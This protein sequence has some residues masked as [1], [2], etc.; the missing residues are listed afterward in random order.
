LSVGK[1]GFSANIYW[2]GNAYFPTTEYTSTMYLDRPLTSDGQHVF[3]DTESALVPQDINN[4]RDVYEYDLASEQVHLIS[5]GTCDCRSNF[6][7]AS[8]DGSNVFFTTYQ[9]LVSAD[10]D[11]AADLYDARIEGGIASQ[12]QVPPPA[13][14]G[15]DCQAPATGAPGFS[16]PSSSTFVGAGNAASKSAP[17]AH[18]KVKSRVKKHKAKHRKK[19]KRSGKR[20]HTTAR[21]HGRQGGQNAR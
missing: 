1:A 5:G 13:C 18:K 3:F 19:R 14:T 9:K 20:S 7:D 8:P 12:N 11:A 6:V 15:D 16:L 21:P 2:D 17:V 10:D 4:R